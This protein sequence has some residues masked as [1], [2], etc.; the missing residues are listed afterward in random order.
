MTPWPSW[1]NAHVDMYIIHTT[2]LVKSP[3]C[4]ALAPCNNLVASHPVPLTAWSTVLT[5]DKTDGL[6]FN[7]QRSVALEL[8]VDCGSSIVGARPQI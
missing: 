4:L 5:V 2:V 3:M 8:A 7:N 1:L 6:L